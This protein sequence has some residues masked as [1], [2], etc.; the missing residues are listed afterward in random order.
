MKA[1]YITPLITIILFCSNIVSGNPIDSIQQLL[2]VKNYSS[3]D[4]YIY[5]ICQG[6]NRRSSNKPIDRELIS[7]YFETVIR[8]TESKPTGEPN[9]SSVYPYYITLVRHNDNII[10]YKLIDEHYVNQP[11]IMVKDKSEPSYTNFKTLYKQIFGRSLVESLLFLYED[12]TFVYGSHCSS[13]GMDP[14]YR[15]KLNKAIKYNDTITLRYWVSSTV[16]EI[17]V[18][19]VEGFYKLTQKGINPSKSDLKKINAIKRKKGNINFCSGCT[20]FKVTIHEA[21]K[22]FIFE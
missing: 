5:K 1:F 14:L 6:N 4:T 8:Y 22:D 20:Y 17:Q 2:K 21:T 11:C 12:N 16:T 19:G 9:V 7:N 13:V 15:Q 10:F 3:L 18:Y